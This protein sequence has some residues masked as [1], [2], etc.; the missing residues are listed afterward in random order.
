[1]RILLTG[2]QGQLGRELRELASTVGHEVWS[3][4]RSDCD[5]TDAVAVRRTIAEVEP[6]ALINC[7]AW[8]RVD[9][10]ESD[11]DGAFRVNALG[12]RVLAAACAGAG[13]LLVHLST[14]YV[15]DGSASSPVDEWQ[16]PNP[17]SVYGASKLA[18]EN[19]VRTLAR[20][21]LVVRTSWLYGREGPN[22]VLTILRAAREGRPLRVVA[23]QV[24]SPTW[25]GHLAPALLR[26]VARDIP[27]TFHLTSSGAVSWHGLAEAIVQ[28]TAHP[29]PVTPITSAEYPTPA[30]RPAYSVLD[31]RAWRLLGEEPLPGWRDGV[32]SY[33]ASLRPEGTAPAR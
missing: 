32:T 20:R 29:A 1:M 27:G 18:G 2:G 16:Q 4:T 12:P 6:D 9:A 11:S 21:H 24:G 23:D 14:D 10:A 30:A 31:N 22:F 17:R 33:L 7:A 15:F 13:V 5:I 3:T 25:T 19:E 26:L 28:S 8:T